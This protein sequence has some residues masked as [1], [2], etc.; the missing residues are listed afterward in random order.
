MS[1][2][3]GQALAG[4]YPG[5]GG[6]IRGKRDG[7]QRALADDHRVHE[8][9]GHVLRVGAGR[10]D[11]EDDQLAAPVESHRHGVTGR[12]YILRVGGQVT[13]RRVPAVEKL[14]NC[15]ALNGAAAVR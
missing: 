10:A 13:H 1:E 7:G 12:R 3:L 6:H 15:V 9:H 8:L 5:H 11:A 4:G 2:D 14:G